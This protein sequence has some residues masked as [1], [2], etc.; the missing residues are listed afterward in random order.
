MQLL[1]HC[2]DHF[3]FFSVL[4]FGNSINFC[5]LATC[6]QCTEIARR[7]YLIV[8]HS[9]ISLILIESYL[10]SSLTSFELHGK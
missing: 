8:H 5:H 4:F 9:F 10:V 1:T 3:I 2:E 7:S 6:D